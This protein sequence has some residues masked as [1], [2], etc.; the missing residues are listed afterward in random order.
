MART[1]S[2][3]SAEPVGSAFLAFSQE[4]EMAYEDKVAA[5]TRLFEDP[6][7]AHLNALAGGRY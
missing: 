4:V 5:V 7:L 3:A 6:L 2:L 1:T